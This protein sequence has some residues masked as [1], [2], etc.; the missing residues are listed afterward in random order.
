MVRAFTQFQKILSEKEIIK[1]SKKRKNFTYTIL[2][3]FNTYGEDQYSSIPYSE[4][5]Q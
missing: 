4:I 5:Y 3:F 2:R 1:N